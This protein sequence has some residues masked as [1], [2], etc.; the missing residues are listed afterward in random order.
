MQ[1][2]ITKAKDLVFSSTA[3]DTY[4]LF[5]GNIL[6]A[7][8]GFVYIIFV[9]N[10]LSKESFGV[11]SAATNLVVLLISVTDLGL[12]TTVVNF[13]AEYFSK[14]D[15]VNSNR[16]IK[17]SVVIRFLLAFL[18][19]LLVIIFAKNVSLTFLST[20][21]YMVSIWTGIIAL[22]L[23]LPM[24]LPYVLQGQRRYF[25]SAFADNSVYISR[26]IFT[27]LFMYFA[28]LTLGSS[29]IAFA[30][31]G[32]VGSIV[33][34]IL[35]GTK[36]IY[37]DTTKNEYRRLMKFTGWLSVNR[38]LSSI[39]GR[40]DIQM[41]IMLAGPLSTASYSLASRFA[42]IISVFSGSFSGV[43]APRLASF[44][45]KEEIKKYIVKAT[46][47][48]FALSVFLG[49]STFLVRPFFELVSWIV[50][51]FWTGWFDKYFDSIFILKT[52]LLA[53]IPFVLSTPAVSAVIY[54]MK[55]NIHVGLFSFVQLVL[56]VSLNY[57][58]IPIY[59]E[60]GPVITIGIT[61]LV[62]A[63][64]FWT[65]VIRHYWK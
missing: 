38:V 63:I 1:K 26:L 24:I 60:L 28:T 21:D 8:L 19:T 49:M 13:V 39:F 59:G 37:S 2:Y 64:Y 17:A 43:M 18:V 9:S 40:L 50:S 15:Y 58:L 61:Y 4:V 42:G 30:L 53:N 36:F 46:L 54:S 32:F 5:V 29:L 23:A 6:A 3:K 10:I 57:L 65:I 47:A 62:H 11:F 34:L 56:V 20:T 44:E 25:A 14:K 16:F 27:L 12:S 45:N 55:K 41:L 52:L 51:S 33:G 7:F 48:S 31:G 22:S 35:V